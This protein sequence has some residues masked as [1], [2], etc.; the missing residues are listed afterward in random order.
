MNE[1][2][3]LAK[4]TAKKGS[5]ALLEKTVR[6]AMPPTHAEP[7]CLKYSFNQSTD[8]PAEFVMIERWTSKAALDTHLA[9]PHIQELFSKLPALLA[10][11]MEITTYRTIPEG[12]VGKGVV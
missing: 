10:S 3:V 4:A 11:P 12:V 5:E 2:V 1:I 9:S 7:G 6:A 8:N